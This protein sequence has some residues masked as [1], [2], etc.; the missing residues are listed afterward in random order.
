[1]V[2][3]SWVQAPGETRNLCA[4]RTLHLQLPA[5]WGMSKLGLHHCLGATAEVLCY[6][7]LAAGGGCELLTGSW[8]NRETSAQLALCTRSYLQLCINPL[9]LATEIATFSSITCSTLVHCAAVA[10]RVMCCVGPEGW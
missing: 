6:H 5:P 8:G 2:G 9:L 1:V 7:I 10:V 4:A 3:A